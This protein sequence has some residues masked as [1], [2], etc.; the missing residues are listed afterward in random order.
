M[1]CGASS[2]PG[3]RQ[4]DAQQQG[5]PESVDALCECAAVITC[6]DPPGHRRGG[7]V[8]EE[9]ADPDER[10]QDRPGD[11]ERRELRRTEVPDDRRVGQQHERLGHQREERR[12]REAENLPVLGLRP[13]ARSVPGTARARHGRRRWQTAVCHEHAASLC[14]A[15]TCAQALDPDSGRYRIFFFS[16]VVHADETAGQRRGCGCCPQISTGICPT[17]AH[18]IPGFPTVRPHPLWTTG[19]QGSA[20]RRAYGRVTDTVR[21][22]S[23]GRVRLRMAPARTVGGAGYASSR[24]SS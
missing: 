20:T 24:C 5:Q 16:T 10:L 19:Y 4:Y 1:A 3:Q 17:C 13:V 23:R 15:W 9:H 2:E 12:H 18:P 11:A 8:R 22:Q 7:A 14:L 6:A 21:P